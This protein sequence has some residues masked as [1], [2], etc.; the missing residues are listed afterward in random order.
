ME[1]GKSPPLAPCAQ[2]GGG[3]GLQLIGAYHITIMHTA[4]H[5]PF[6]LMIPTLNTIHY[7]QMTIRHTANSNNWTHYILSSQ[8][9]SNNRTSGNLKNLTYEPSHW[10]KR[11]DDIYHVHPVTP[12]GFIILTITFL[13]SQETTAPSNSKSPGA[14]ASN[15][16]ECISVVCHVHC[17]VSRITSTVSCLASRP[18]SLWKVGHYH[19]Q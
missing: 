1:L 2:V 19:Q 13:Q 9:Q 16:Y 8:K 18:D 12:V 7:F 10:Y 15:S 5:H 4:L 3:W 11:L 6:H 14:H 17:I